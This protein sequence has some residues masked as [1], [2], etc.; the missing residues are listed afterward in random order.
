MSTKSEARGAKRKA[1][2]LIVDDHPVVREG[3][4]QRINQEPDLCACGEA[5]DANGA[6]TAIAELK[7]DAAIVDIS[8][9]G[10]S[11]L[12]LIK[13]VKAKY[14]KLPILVLSM[15]DESAYAGRA[16][17]AGAK[18]YV[19]K[20]KPTSN[21]IDG[22]RKILEGQIYLSENMVGKVLH[23]LAGNTLE[24]DQ[25]SL[26]CLTDRELEVFQWIGRGLS[27]REIAEKLNLSVKTI[28]THREHLKQKLDLKNAS[29][30]SHRAYQWAHQADEG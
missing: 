14:P 19:M 17:Q 21:L 13:N 10:R 24:M 5:G 27:T 4:G 15:H 12:E 26:D 22:L 9:E 23:R 25:S 30:L 18:G 6:M 3:V 11:G 8:L 28:E 7:P 1:R 20:G 2:I 29:E 16:L